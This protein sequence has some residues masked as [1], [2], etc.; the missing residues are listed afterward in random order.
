MKKTLIATAFSLCSTGA[1]YAMPVEITSSIPVETVIGPQLMAINTT[2]AD[3]AATQFQI[4]TAINTNSDK[5][6][7]MIEE[8]A[9]T[10]RDYETFARKTE[11]LETARRSYSVPDSI[12]SDSASGMATQVTAGSRSMEG[13]LAGG[14]GIANKAIQTAVSA[15][16]VPLE[17]E[18]FRS[19]SIHANYCS[20]SDFAAYGGTALCQQVSDLPGGDTDIRSILY[21]AGKP[22]KA[23]DMT[24]TQEQTD[25]AMM[26]MKN[27]SQRSAGQQLSKG[28]VKTASG[29]QYIGI[30]NQHQGIQSAAAQPQLA[31]IA[32]SQPN[33]QTKEVLKEALLTP[34][35]AAYFDQNASPEARRT[36]SMSEREFESF[37]VGRR[38]ANTDYLTDLQD[39]EDDNLM[40]E[41]IKVQNLQNWLLLGIKQQ[42]QEGNILS[43]QQLGIAGA[44]EFRPLLQQKLQQVSAGVSRNG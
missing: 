43:G 33:P 8:T 38:Y 6:A 44:Q 14:S 31:M 41:S 27:T 9:K 28:E 7:A 26:Y 40:R 16:A 10:Q 4:G 1:A 3:I 2:L 21:G 37:E 42:L 20:A 24:F 13:Q 25:A 22:D 29:Q 39:M 34:S 18:Q 32:A 30:M 19:A 36:H 12:C 11:R 23:P 17:Q 15:P 35:A 5:L